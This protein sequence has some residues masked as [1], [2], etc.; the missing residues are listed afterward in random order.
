MSEPAPRFR[1]TKQ[2]KLRRPIEFRRIYEGK[3]KAGDNHLLVFAAPNDLGLTRVGLSVSKKHGSA[4]KRNRIKRLLREAFRLSQHDLPTGLDLILIPR[5]ASGA[6]L[7]D[8]R[9]SLAACAGRLVKRL[10]RQV[11]T[12]SRGRK[13]GHGPDES[14]RT[15]SAP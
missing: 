9:R 11:E 15:E 6:T 10:A 3:L 8:Y 7:V 1:L 13:P 5:P 2:Q 12:E 4:V 14:N